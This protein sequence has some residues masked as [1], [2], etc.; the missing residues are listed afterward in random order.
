MKT[1]MEI[2]ADLRTAS[3]AAR[4]ILDGLGTDHRIEYVIE[5]LS[6][7]QQLVEDQYPLSPNDQSSVTIG[8]FAVRELEGVHDELAVRLEHIAYE[9]KK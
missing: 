5:E 1:R 3:E 4:Q 9:L 2:L 6:R 7:L 8:L